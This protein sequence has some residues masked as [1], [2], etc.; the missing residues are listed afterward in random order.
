MIFLSRWLWSVVTGPGSR[1]V[2]RQIGGLV[3]DHCHRVTRHDDEYNSD[4]GAPPLATTR[5][6]AG[7][8][9]YFRKPAVS[10]L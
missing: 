5:P 3:L 4:V 10:P 8:D 9:N 2:I 7:D 6:L 1:H